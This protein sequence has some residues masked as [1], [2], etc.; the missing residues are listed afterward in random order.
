[1]KEDGNNN[2]ALYHGGF[3]EDIFAITSFSL[4]GDE[5]RAVVDFAI[6]SKPTV[7]LAL[8]DT[9]LNNISIICAHKYEPLSGFS[10]DK[11][12]PQ[13]IEWRFATPLIKTKKIEVYGKIMKA[14]ALETCRSLYIIA[15]IGDG[16]V[17]KGIYEYEP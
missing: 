15:S 3:D 6:R 8:L 1:M 17:F 7:P 9:L 5:F 2:C 13:K 14:T 4:S 16:V 11:V 10:S 12:K